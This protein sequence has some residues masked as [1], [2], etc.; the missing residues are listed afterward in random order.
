MTRSLTSAFF[1]K[2]FYGTQTKENET[3]GTYNMHG[4]LRSAYKIFAGK[5]EEKRSLVTHR[6]RTESDPRNPIYE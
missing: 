2:Y 1:N 5:S 4:M 3:D 6:R